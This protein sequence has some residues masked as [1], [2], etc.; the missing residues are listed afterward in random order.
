[1]SG[2]YC[3]NFTVYII[4]ENL[5]QPR[6]C[7]EA[8]SLIASRCLSLTVLVGPSMCLHL[9]WSFPLQANAQTYHLSPS[10]VQQVNESESFVFN[11]T[12]ETGSPPFFFVLLD[13]SVLS[14]R[15]SVER[16]SGGSR[17]TVGPVTS[18]DDGSVL[19]CSAHNV[20]TVESATLDVT[21]E[22]YSC[23]VCTCCSDYLVT[24][25]CIRCW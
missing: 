4:I 18:S 25:L 20:F 10:G 2:V 19:Q 3:C 1:M 12:V 21:G 23:V 16:I 13:G 9:L 24:M 11:C 8:S 5:W 7:E 14:T 17:Y 22:C 15:L 6:Q